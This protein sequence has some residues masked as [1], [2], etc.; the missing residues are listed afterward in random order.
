MSPGNPG[1]PM[2]AKSWDLNHSCFPV[3]WYIGHRE[4]PASFF[5][6]RQLVTLA[7][8]ELFKTLFIL[9]HYE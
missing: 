6:K 7:R 5:Q 3:S 2:D 1:A 4:N 8:L 9:F